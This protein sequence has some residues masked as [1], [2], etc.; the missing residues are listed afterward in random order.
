[1]NTQTGKQRISTDLTF[2]AD[3]VL[4]VYKLLWKFSKAIEVVLL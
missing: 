1:M 4:K 3:V 2:G